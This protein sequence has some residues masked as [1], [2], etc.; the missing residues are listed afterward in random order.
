MTL[1]EMAVSV[2]LLGIVLFLLAGLA[3]TTRQRAKKQLTCR[4]LCSLDTALGAYV[5]RYKAPPPGVPDGSADR[6]IAALLAYGASSAELDGLPGVLR[7]TKGEV[8]TLVDPW[9]TPL[10]YVTGEHESP[11]MR[12]RV[13]TNGGRPLFDS[14]GPDR[15]FGPTEDRPDG[16]DIWGDECLLEPKR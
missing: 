7:T 13:A 3:R 12:D 14:A 16:S 1:V 11:A 10:R 8:K 9:G 15:R 4:L 6:A 5:D 2:L